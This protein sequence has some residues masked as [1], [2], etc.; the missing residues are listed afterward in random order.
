M[1]ITIATGPLLPVPAVKGGAVQKL[2]H[3]LAIEF[4]R[5]GHAVTIVARSFPGQPDTEIRDGI[6][7]IR[8]GG[9]DQSLSVRR[10]LVKNF[11][12]S[13]HVLRHLPAADILVTN[14]F[15][16]P[17]FAGWLRSSAGKIVV[18]ANRFPKGQF[19]L[20]RRAARIAAASS[21]V[22]NAVDRQCPA[23]AARTLV[24]P[25]PVDTNLLQP[26]APKN[27]AE[28][29]LLF[30]GRLHP[31]KG[32]HLLIEAFATFVK[33]N[34]N[35][36]LQ[37]VGPVNTDHGG[38]GE[39][40]RRQLEALAAGLPVE[41]T[42][43]I[44]DPAK[45]A[46]VYQQ[47]DLFCYPSLAETGEALPVAPLEALACGVPV[48]VSALDCFQDYVTEGMTGFY[49]DHRAGNP[50]A[51][52]AAQLQR[53]VAAPEQLARM[54]QQAVATAQQFSYPAVA[55]KYLDDFATLTATCP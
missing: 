29:F 16:L 32:V 14:D 12:D 52:L 55:K 13:A 23:L 47:A 46:T 30:V 33:A 51:Q 18:N 39:N 8:I 49:F 43:S 15:W 40:Y 1:K 28:K 20:Y 17:V 53:A 25:N 11:F 4:A 7:F 44:F 38:G 34:P 36:R 10:D 3:G 37:L 26:A 48:V 2:W 42:G 27:R 22:K 21:A 5:R 31:E 41:F 9:F 6:R 54:G 24:L 19:G 35:W 45:L 50:A